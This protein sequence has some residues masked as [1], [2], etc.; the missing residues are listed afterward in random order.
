MGLSEA[1]SDSRLRLKHSRIKPKTGFNKNVFIYFV[2]GT[3]IMCF[4]HTRDITINKRCFLYCLSFYS[5][6]PRFVSKRQTLPP[7]SQWGSAKGEHTQTIR[8][9]EDNVCVPH[10]RSQHL[11][12]HS[13]HMHTQLSGSV[14]ITPS[15]VVFP[16]PC[17]LFVN[18]LH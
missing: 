17:P 8:W 7:E 1:G 15:L 5:F 9:R 11:S 2:P 18:S 6:L 14:S 3:L 4:M 12:G 16:T 13:P 10:R